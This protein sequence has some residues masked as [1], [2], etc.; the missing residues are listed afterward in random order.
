MHLL[1]DII[2]MHALVVQNVQGILEV[3]LVIVGDAAR[4]RHLW[5]HT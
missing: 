2:T 1:I 4:K 5:I 3:I